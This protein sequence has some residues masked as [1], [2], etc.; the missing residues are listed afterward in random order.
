MATAEEVLETMAEVPESAPVCVI[1]PETRTI[2]VPPDYQ[3]FGVE[4]DKRVERLYFQCPKIVGDNQDLSQEYQLFMNYQNANG[5]PDAYH[6]DDMEV[7]GDNITF[8]WLL[9]ENVTKYRGNIQFAFG[10]I[11]PGDETEDPDKNRWNTTI[12]TECTCLVG[13]KCTQQVAESNPDALVQI[14]AAIDELKAGGG[15]GTGGTTNY[16]NLSNKPRLNGVTLEGNKTLDQ[17]GVLAKNQGSNNS[18]KFLSVG[19]DGNVVPADAPSGGTVDPEQ[20]KQAVNGYLEENPVSGMTAEQ[21]Q[22][23]NQNTSDVSDLKSALTELGNNYKSEYFLLKSPNGQVYKITISNSGEIIPTV[24]S[25]GLPDIIPGRLL[26]WSDEF[27]SDYINTDIWGFE[28]GYIRNNEKQYYVSDEKNAYVS[29]SILHIVALKD[30][31]YSGYEWSSASL[32][33]QLNEKNGFSYGYGLIEIKARCTTPYSGVWPAFWSR[34]ASQPG[35]GWPMCGEIDIGELFYDGDS[36]M[37]HYNP[38]IFW[39]DWHSL[40]RKSQKSTNTGDSSGQV[41]YQNVDTDWHCYGLERNENVMIFYF[42]RNEISRI[43]LTE[44]SDSDINSA[45]K[46]PMSV[47]LNLAMGSSG[48]EIPSNLTKAEYEIDYVRYYAPTGIEIS[49]D[50]GEWNFPDYMPSE[51]GYSKIARIIPNREMNDGKN[52]FLY[53]ESSNPVIASVDSGLITTYE[54]TGNVDISMHDVFGNTKTVNLSVKEGADCK[55][56]EVREIPTNPKIIPWG[57][58]IDIL[59]RLVPNWVTNH[60]V[61]ASLN[62]A[63][64][65]VSVSVKKSTHSIAKYTTECSIIELENNSILLEDTDIILKVTAQDSGVFLD[66]PITIKKGFDDFDTS[67]MYAAYLYE[68][69]NEIENGVGQLN[70]LTKNNKNPI[71]NLYYTATNNNGICRIPGKGIQSQVQG[72]YFNPIS[73]EGFFL[74]KFDKNRTLTF[75]FNIMSGSTEM[76]GAYNMNHGLLSV[77][78]EGIGHNIVSNTVDGRHGFSFGLAYNDNTENGFIVKN[79]L[80]GDTSVSGFVSSKLMSNENE[81]MPENINTEYLHKDNFIYSVVLVYDSSDKSMASHIVVNGKILATLYN[82]LKY[83]KSQTNFDKNVFETIDTTISE[84]IL[85]EDNDKPFYW[86]YGNGGQVCSDFVRAICVYDKTLSKEEMISIDSILTN[87]YL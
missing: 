79:V 39:Y 62:P 82:G 29:D 52:Q 15:G 13:L 36:A 16:E 51:L 28:Q 75:V 76:R 73:A 33:S 60:D 59:V 72:G 78:H 57:E 5:D 85:Q 4:N 6:I 70:T 49:T 2:I 24:F 21:E 7:D 67:G 30:N 47:K 45:M 27:D 35:E 32:D 53:W 68:Y 77:C 46:Q 8:S 38:G 23:L 12:N 50:S 22:Q 37:H 65:G 11:I 34:G 10:A 84:E 81:I 86:R 56:T 63:L 83:A 48:G 54:Q 69:T 43:N 66:I 9:E 20:I 14:W 3:L 61:L 71:T 64:D 80:S 42:D 31:P 17:V 41:I 74:E 19:S 87:R 1:D 26:L 25:G 18:G 55:S 40:L 44:L 58:K